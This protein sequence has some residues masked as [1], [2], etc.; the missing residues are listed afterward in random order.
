MTNLDD[1]IE[2]KLAELDA[3]KERLLAA[4]KAKAARG[5]PTRPAQAH[6]PN[7]AP[8]KND[9]YQKS[10]GAGLARRDS[11][12]YRMEKIKRDERF[13][14]DQYRQMAMNK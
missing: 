14:A 4:A 5:Q 7:M 11:D 12:E 10:M 1:D 3:Q 6:R 2:Q 13:K 8:S 9:V